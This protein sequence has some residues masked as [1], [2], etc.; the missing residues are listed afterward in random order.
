MTNTPHDETKQLRTETGE[1]KGQFAGNIPTPPVPSIE[2]VAPAKPATVANDALEAAQTRAY[3][4]EREM[5]EAAEAAIC[6]AVTNAFPKA[7]VD[8][9]VFTSEFDGNGHRL[10]FQKLVD[11]NNKQLNLADDES[12]DAD[13]DK[14]DALTDTLSNLGDVFTDGDY[15]DSCFLRNGNGYEIQIQEWPVS[16]P[17]TSQSLATEVEQID[18]QIEALT[19]RKMQ[20]SRDGLIV[21]I[22]ESFEDAQTV[23]FYRIP[24]ADTVVVDAI[25]DKG[26]R[27][28]WSAD[29]SYGDVQLDRKFNVFARNLDEGT[30][31]IQRDARGN[32]VIQMDLGPAV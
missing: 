1:G 31:P 10:S 12:G 32:V 17:A 29:D 19:A 22:R 8:R 30:K 14:L 23:S 7:G 18:A 13:Y 9:A 24:G 2:L 27:V 5:F 21:A 25:A 3:T 4:A 16:Q 6:E 11:A 26:G 15:V 20:V 28:L